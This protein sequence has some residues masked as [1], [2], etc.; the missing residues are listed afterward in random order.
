MA[1]LKIWQTSIENEI[2]CDGKEIPFY[3]LK[4]KLR[5]FLSEDRK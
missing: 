1:T 4:I 2:D 5:K 3:R